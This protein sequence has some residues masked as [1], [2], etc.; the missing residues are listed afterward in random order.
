MRYLI[1]KM[2]K[3]IDKLEI[4]NRISDKEGSY[5]IAVIRTSYND[6]FYYCWGLCGIAH[7]LFKNEK[8]AFVITFLK[9]IK[10][11]KE[12]VDAYWWPA[13]AS[14]ERWEV[15]QNIQVRKNFLESVLKN[16]LKI[17]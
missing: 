13:M 14:D 1:S 3:Q 9:K 8:A 4:L 7:F 2:L 12:L 17:F 5:F 6:G 11:P 15:I 10:Q 16:N